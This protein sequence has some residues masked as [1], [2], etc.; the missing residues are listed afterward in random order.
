MNLINN[1]DKFSYTVDAYDTP[2]PRVRTYVRE[3]YDDSDVWVQNLYSKYSAKLAQNWYGAV[4]AGYL[5]R[6]FAG[7]SGAFVRPLGSNWA[8]G[9]DLNRVRVRFN[10]RFGLRDY[11]VWTGHLECLLADP[12]SGRFRSRGLR[13]ALF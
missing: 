11:K 7:V 2:L 4:Y 5:E 13:G 1:Y 6:M 10:S 8:F 3:Y 9:A 12:V